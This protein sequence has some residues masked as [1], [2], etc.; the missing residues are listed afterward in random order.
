MGDST[1]VI[2]S[3]RL[4]ITVARTLSLRSSAN[5]CFS[6]DSRRELT[7][8]AWKRTCIHFT[9][10]AIAKYLTVNPSP[11]GGNR[12]TQKKP[13]TFGKA[14]TNFSSH[15]GHEFEARMHGLMILTVNSPSEWL[16]PVNSINTGTITPGKN[17]MF[18]WSQDGG[19]NYK[20]RKQF[21]YHFPKLFALF[22]KDCIE[23]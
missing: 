14:L 8:S 19:N 1:I 17:S 9:L 12:S 22:Q 7:I 5:I 16:H 13:T 20:C 10:K 2:T 15:K 3:A 11:V 4:L 6:I 21:S 23:N 18:R